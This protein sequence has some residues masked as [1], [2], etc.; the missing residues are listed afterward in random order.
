MKSPFSELR[1]LKRWTWYHQSN[2]G[3]CPALP[4][5]SPACWI[6]YEQAKKAESPCPGFGFLRGEGFIGID[7]DDCISDGMMSGEAKAILDLCQGSYAEVSKSGK[8]IK[9]WGIGNKSVLQCN[10]KIGNQKV[11]LYDN[12]KWFMSTGRAIKGHSTMVRKIGE[13][14]EHIEAHQEKRRNVEYKPLAKSDAM[15]IA[16]VHPGA[17]AGCGG[18]RT[19]FILAKKLLLAGCNEEEAMSLL[20]QIHNPMCKPQWSVRELQHKIES[21]KKSLG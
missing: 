16:M 17:I 7:L 18:H 15:A 11:E 8:G 1:L 12:G 5:S 9:I 21:A 10:Y 3:K 4:I 19:T 2:D 6:T 20:K 13:A 14:I